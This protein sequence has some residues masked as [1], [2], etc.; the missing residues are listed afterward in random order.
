MFLSEGAVPQILEPQFQAKKHT[1]NE[2]KCNVK[3]CKFASLT[4]VLHVGVRRPND[5]KITS[6]VCHHTFFFVKFQLGELGLH[7]SSEIMQPNWKPEQANYTTV[8]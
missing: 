7:I 5:I 2:M 1:Q 8:N 4:E 3:K 6:V